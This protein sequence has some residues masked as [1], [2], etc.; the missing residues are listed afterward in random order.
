METR[1]GKSDIKA[2]R[3][4]M[5]TS[6]ILLFAAFLGVFAWACSSPADTAKKAS[7]PGSNSNS[8]SK[9]QTTDPNIAVVNTAPPAN[10]R[11][12]RMSRKMIDANPAGT[13][14]SPQFHPA[15]EDSE[16][17]VTMNR[18]GAVVE[19]RVFKSHPQLARVEVTWLDPKNKDVKFYLR[20]GQILNVK[21]MRIGN[22]QTATTQELLAIAGQ[23]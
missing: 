14:P 21:T 2:R 4:A 9:V 16:S 22:L 3:D 13:P 18:D 12:R 17:A 8:P 7:G 10:M 5:R 23:K 6:K 1:K 20:S 15:A 11:D 19:I